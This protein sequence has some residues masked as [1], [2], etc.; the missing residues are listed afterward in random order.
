MNTQKK[1][2]LNTIQTMI[3]NYLTVKLN[4]GCNLSNM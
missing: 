2:K 4:V 3:Y 1:I